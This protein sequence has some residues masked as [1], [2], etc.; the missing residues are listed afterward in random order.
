MTGSAVEPVSSRHCLG[1]SRDNLDDAGACQFTGETADRDRVMC[2]QVSMCLPVY[3]PACPVRMI[4]AS[5]RY[6]PD[7]MRHRLDDRYGRQ[8]NSVPGSTR[9]C[10]A[11]NVVTRLD[12]RG[13]CA[14]APVSLC[15]HLKTVVAGFP[16]VASSGYLTKADPQRPPAE[17]L[18]VWL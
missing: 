10:R 17:R 18:P 15:V 6:L 11:V 14:G 8:R 9:I 16:G 13:K 1:L 3:L 5:L 7:Y 2:K 12:V 4:A